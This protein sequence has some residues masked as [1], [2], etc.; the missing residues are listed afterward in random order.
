MKFMRHMKTKM[1][2]INADYHGHPL[3]LDIPVIGSCKREVTNFYHEVH[4]VHEVFSSV[5]SWWK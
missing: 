3:S 4:E 5:P 1:P 2:R